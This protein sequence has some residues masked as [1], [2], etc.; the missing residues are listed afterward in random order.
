MAGVRPLT[1]GGAVNGVSNIYNYVGM[2]VI[3][4]KYRRD[5]T[6]DKGVRD[7]V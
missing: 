2:P 1:G 3:A 5:V 6:A 7:G 4:I